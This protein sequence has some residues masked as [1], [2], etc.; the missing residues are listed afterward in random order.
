MKFVRNGWLEKSF[1]R[2]FPLARPDR[3]RETWK[4]A[5]PIVYSRY[6]LERSS[7]HPL[8]TTTK[9]RAHPTGDGA[10]CRPPADEKRA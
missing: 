7:P 2:Q 6:C 8:F 1:F 3:I 4:P 10:L 5:A 9:K